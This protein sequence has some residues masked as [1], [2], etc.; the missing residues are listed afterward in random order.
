MTYGLVLKSNLGNFSLTI[1][2]IKY[3]S[4]SIIIRTETGRNLKVCVLVPIQNKTGSVLFVP[5]YPLA[6]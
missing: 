4:I 1:E 2:S 5:N 6:F 3:I